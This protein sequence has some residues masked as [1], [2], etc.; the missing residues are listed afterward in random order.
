MPPRSWAGQRGALSL[1]AGREGGT[2]TVPWP[3]A[4][5]ASQRSSQP[6]RLIA[7]ASVWNLAPTRRAPSPEQLWIRRRLSGHGPRGIDPWPAR[8]LRQ[9]SPSRIGFDGGPAGTRRTRLQQTWTCDAG[10]AVKRWCGQTRA[11][12]TGRDLRSCAGSVAD[13][14]RAARR[15]TVATAAVVGRLD[16]HARSELVALDQR[17][18][19][20]PDA[21]ADDQIA[22]PVHED[23][24]VVGLGH[25]LGDRDHVRGA[26]RASPS[27]RRH[28]GWYGRSAAPRSARGAA[29]RG[30]GR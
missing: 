1:G 10:R 23:A 9:R 13:A 30:T 27:V 15:T 11:M 18:D 3:F 8:C 7:A 26:A 21:R 4:S 6:S 12:V 14:L 22:F 20:G 16:E 17:G 2:V 28:D 5:L 24:P 29:R 25:A 19:R